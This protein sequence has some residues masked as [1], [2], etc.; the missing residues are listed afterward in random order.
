M[1]PTFYTFTEPAPESEPAPAPAPDPAHIRRRFSRVGLSLTV[2]VAVMMAAAYV[3]MFAVVLV[4][5]QL[6]EAWWMNWL[7]SLLPLYGAALPCA[8][9]ILRKVPVTPHNPTYVDSYHVTREKTKFGFG[10]W[11]ILLVMGLGCMYLGNIVGT[12]IMNSLSEALDYDYANALNEVIESSPLWMI[13]IG[14]CICAP[15]GE[16]LIFRKLLLDRTR[17]FGEMASIILSGLLFGLFHGNLFQFFYAFLLGMILA[18]IYLRSGDVRWC[19][20]MHAVINFLGSIAMPRLAGLVPT[21]PEATLTLT[22]VMITL[23]LALWMYGL[24]ITAAVLLCALWHRRKVSPGP[25]GW[26]VGR[27][28]RTMLL[29]PGMIAAVVVMVLLLAANLIPVR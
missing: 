14:T 25:A 11:M 4:A 21:D 18:Y 12:I 28:L 19:I 7:L 1:D 2:L 6:S 20:A 26:S 29:N 13:F 5:P 10:H 23:F 15:I 24:I 27:S 17:G 16:E 8:Y 3:I 22:Q 9:L